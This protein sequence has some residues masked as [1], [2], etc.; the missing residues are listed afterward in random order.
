MPEETQVVS[1]QA[2]EI[3]NYYE[4]SLEKKRRLP[5]ATILLTY[6]E[7][8]T[9]IFQRKGILNLLEDYR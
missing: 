9:V 3:I 1:K 4:P 8:K 5:E 2:D 6:L 7:M